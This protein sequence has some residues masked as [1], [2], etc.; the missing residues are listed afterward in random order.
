M[1][2]AS[3]S[4]YIKVGTLYVKTRVLRALIFFALLISI[5]YYSFKGHEQKSTSEEIFNT[6]DDDL[7]SISERPP[8]LTTITSKQSLINGLH[9]DLNRL[10]NVTQGAIYNVSASEPWRRPYALVD[11][12]PEVRSKNSNLTN[13]AKTA[14]SSKSNS[15]LSMLASLGSSL[16]T[17]LF[18]ESPELISGTPTINSRV[19]VYTFYNPSPGDSDSPIVEVWKRAM[20][21]AG[22]E[23]VVLNIDDCKKHDKF[24]MFEEASA[25]NIDYF[26]KNM[27]WFAW[28]AK[29]GGILMDYRVIPVSRGSLTSQVGLL[30]RIKF[31]SDG[32]LKRYEPM[33]LLLVT[34]GSSSE[35]IVR[36]V[37]D[38]ENDN[39]IVDLFDK[40]DDEDERDTFAYYSAENVKT[41]S[42]GRELSSLEIAKLMNT[43]LHHAFLKQ[44]QTQGVVVIDPLQAGA[45]ALTVPGEFI[46]TQL[47]KCPAND[48]FYN[49]CPPIIR[50]VTEAELFTAKKVPF[51]ENSKGLCNNP[52]WN[53][54]S[55]S[56]IIPVTNI[57]YLPELDSNHFAIMGYPH[58]L[59]VLS[60]LERNA[61]VSVH[62]SRSR[63][64]RNTLVRQLTSQYIPGNTVGMNHRLLLL[65]D[66]IYQA[67][68][69][70][71]CIW[72]NWE[73]AHRSTVEETHEFLQNLSWE[74]GFE[75]D[76]V[77][78]LSTNSLTDNSEEAKA[79]RAILDASQKRALDKANKD[80]MGIEA[81]NLADTEIWKFLAAFTQVRLNK[82]HSL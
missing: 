65:K 61:S 76:L 50:L 29:G 72:F 24:K 26:K 79:L 78:D 53:D 11:M 69:L 6:N 81:W 28:A 37:L 52:C 44:F 62:D 73:D 30:E 51:L 59:S 19:K 22:F 32:F 74:V 54:D 3:N 21:A 34:G 48:E 23:P 46:A 15:W 66:A 43:H 5:I 64:Q 80:R 39:N 57:E 17:S 47:A 60:V 31:Y 20:W 49:V 16:P 13:T 82:I 25:K 71:N 63:I 2:V 68:A 7:D 8:W 18:G 9:L 58:P 42:N 56:T 55:S 45:H 12:A 33:K 77:D 27:K 40:Y 41:M 70:S 38:F 35:R 14:V 1:S 36:A 4:P 75:M 67:P 10:D